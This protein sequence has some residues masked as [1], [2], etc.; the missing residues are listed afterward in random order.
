MP[1]QSP[2]SPVEGRGIGGSTAKGISSPVSSTTHQ[3]T[4]PGTQ[5]N[6]EDRA[7]HTTA[8][9]VVLSRVQGHRCD[10]HVEEDGE[11]ELTGGDLPELG[12]GHKGHNG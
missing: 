2:I 3:E 7:V 11:Q 12:V 4:H 6:L 1:K 9:Q 10:A 8:E 5:F